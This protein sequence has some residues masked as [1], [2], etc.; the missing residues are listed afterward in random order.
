MREL[1]RRNVVR[2]LTVA[3]FSLPAVGAASVAAETPPAIKGYDPVAYFTVGKAVL[4]SPAFELAWDDQRYRFSSADHRAMFEANP[5]RYAPHF[6]N[7]CAMALARGQ[8]VE[9]NPEYWLITDGKLYLF[10]GPQGPA[11]FQQDLEGNIVKANES[12][13]RPARN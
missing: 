7:F 6:Q 5:A 8:N 2:G 10:A 11:L 1:S 9:A 13:V 12:A 3:V 4:G